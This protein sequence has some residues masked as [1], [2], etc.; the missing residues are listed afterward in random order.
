MRATPF[1]L[2]SIVLVALLLPVT[3][4]EAN[5]AIAAPPAPGLVLWNKL[6]IG[7]QEDWMVE[8]GASP[9]APVKEGRGPALRLRLAQNPLFLGERVRRGC[10]GLLRTSAA[11]SEDLNPSGAAALSG[12]NWINS[13]G[14]GPGSARR[15][16]D[17]DCHRQPSRRQSRA[18]RSRPTGSRGLKPPWRRPLPCKSLW[19]S[20]RSSRYPAGGLV[21][22]AFGSD[23]TSA[24]PASGTGCA[25]MPPS[26]PPSVPPEVVPV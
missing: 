14:P 1:L 7:G 23:S 10:P 22:S 6:G 24:P 13:N 16:D 12:T 20:I 9:R 26:A 11:G 2:A 19:R 18:R 25:T 5:P 3:A 4:A 8:L 15:G 21:D 17:R